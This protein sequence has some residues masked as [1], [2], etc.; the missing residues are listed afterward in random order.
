MIAIVELHWRLAWARALLWVATAMREGETTPEVHFYLADLH[1]QL[2]DAYRKRGWRIAAVR[3]RRIA[4]AHADA[5]PP[6]SSPR[7]A[8]AL[9]M[10]V[11][12][13]SIFTDARGTQFDPDDV[14]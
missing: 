7:P 14:A 12:Q 13:P 9:A 11:P 1:Y 3:Q 5:A 10:P 8:A 4:E 6:P 2:A